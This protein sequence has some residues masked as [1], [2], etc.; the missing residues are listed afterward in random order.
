MKNSVKQIRRSESQIR[1]LLKEREK[2]NISAKEFC[3]IHEIHRATFYNWLNKYRPKIEKPE[4]F[5]A[6]QLN[7][8][9]SEA[10][11]FAEI[12]FSGKVT[13]RLF[14]KVDASYFK[15]LLKS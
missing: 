13:V 7:D 3:E 10:S 15:A 8:I 4:E 1:A 9:V 11:L 2:S 5:I 12:V 6:V 14:Q